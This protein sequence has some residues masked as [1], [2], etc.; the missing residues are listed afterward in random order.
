MPEEIT[1]T[2]GD[3]SVE[4]IY[5]T[6]DMDKEGREDVPTNMQGLKTQVKDDA[7]TTTFS[8]KFLTTTPS[9]TVLPGAASTHEVMKAGTPWEG[10]ADGAL[11]TPAAS[12]LGVMTDETE[13]GGTEPSTFIP[14]TLHQKTTIQGHLRDVEGSASGDSEASGQFVY[15]PDKDRI[16]SPLPPH[17]SPVHT[18]T[19][20]SAEYTK[21]IGEAVVGQD[22]HGAAETGSG[23]EQ[24]TEEGKDSEGKGGLVD[25]PV[26]ADITVLPTPRDQVSSQVRDTTSKISMSITIPTHSVDLPTLSSSS[27]F[28]TFDRSSQSVPQW[29]LSPDPSATPLKEEEFVDYHGISKPGLLESLQ[30]TLVDSG[31]TEQTQTGTD[32]VPSVEDSSV[33][34]KGT[35]AWLMGV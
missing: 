5:Y 20:P 22:V 10:S 23:S 3:P 7:A 30:K 4:P 2:E 16:T 18:Q 19:P 28:Y 32:S 35:R 12:L 17:H 31:A 27:L 21:T 34:V 14:D 1:E 26:E 25:L 33:D 29:A 8:P 9:D 13:V 15:Q 24:L 11:P 6:K